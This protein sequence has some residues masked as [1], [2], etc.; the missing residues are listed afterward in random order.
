[1]KSAPKVY[2]NLR[3]IEGGAKY[4]NIVVGGQNNTDGVRGDILNTAGK[5]CVELMTTVDLIEGCIEQVEQIDKQK[6]V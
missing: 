1:M 6:G 3:A 5:L 4:I 2:R